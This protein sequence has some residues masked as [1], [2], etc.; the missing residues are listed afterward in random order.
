MEE[1]PR[2]ALDEEVVVDAELD[3]GVQTLLTCRQHLVQ[4]REA[5]FLVLILC[6]TISFIRRLRYFNAFPDEET[7]YKFRKFGKSQL[8]L[9]WDFP[10]FR[11]LYGVKTSHTLTHKPLAEDYSTGA[12]S[13]LFMVM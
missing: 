12:V 4:L 11:N 6:F 1:P 5:S 3:H 13:T 10:N 9:S 8:R 2:D 7:P